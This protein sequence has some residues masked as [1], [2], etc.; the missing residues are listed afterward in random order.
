MEKSA[1]ALL[2]AFQHRINDTVNLAPIITAVHGFVCGS[3]RTKADIVSS[4]PR[5]T[6]LRNLLN[7][8]HT[9]GHAYESLLSPYVLHGECVAIG[10]V[11]EAQVARYLGHLSD[12]AVA[13]LTRCIETYK[14]PISPDDAQVRRR[15][16]NMVT[17]FAKLWEVM[18]IDKK[19]VGNDKKVVILTAIGSCLEKK[20]TLV[21]D[22]VFK[23]VLS[24]NV[25]VGSMNNSPPHVE[26]TPPG[27]KSISNRVLVLAALGSG[28]CQIKNLLHS[29][30]TEVMLNAI[31]ALSGVS[32]SWENNCETLVIEGTGKLLAPEEP[33]YL[34]NAGT[35]A[36]FLT[37]ISTLAEAGLAQDT[38]LTGNDRMKQRPIGPLVDALRANGSKIEY[39]E[40]DGSLPLRI[41]AGKKLKGGLI[42]LSATISSQ[43]VSSILMCAP[44]AS[45]PVT[46]ALVG[47]KPISQVFID[48]TIAMM[49]TFGISVQEISKNTYKIPL[50]TYKNPSEYVVESDASSATYPLAFAALSGTS[51]TIP[52]IGSASLQGDARF[53]VDILEP[54]GCKVSQTLTST[55]VQ[56]PAVG[57]LK[58]IPGNVDMEPMTDAFLTATVLAAVS[59]G[60]TRITGIAN[61]RVKECNRI[62]AMIHELDKFGVTT[63]EHSDGLEIDGSTIDKLKTPTDGVDTYDDHR[64]AMSLSLLATSLEPQVLLHDRRCVEKTWP[65]WW[66]ILNRVLKVPLAGHSHPQA[67]PKM[68]IPNED[69]TIV[70]IGMRGAGKSSMGRWVASSLGLKFKDMDDYMEEKLGITIP[71]LIKRDGWEGFR[72]EELQCLDEFLRDKPRGY[73]AACGGGI[74]E[75]PAAR[76]IL[77]DWMAKDRL[78][79]HVHRNIT[80]IV[81]YLQVDK[82]RPSYTADIFDIW[83]RREQWYFDCSNCFY[84]S[85]Y[86]SNS[87]ESSKVRHSLGLFLK[88][89]T[90]TRS[91]KVPRGRSAYLS[92]NFPDLKQVK[93]LEA[94]FVGVSAVELRIDLLRE[95][96]QEGP[97]PSL[98]YVNEQIGYL[99]MATY[100]PIVF[101]IR[102]VS[103]GGK[104]PD[105][106]EDAA[107]KLIRLAYKLG[108]DLV[109]LE[110][111][112]S[113]ALIQKLVADKG[114]T[115][116]IASYQNEAGNLKWDHSTWEDLYVKALAVGD[117]I[118][119]VGRATSLEDNYALETFRQIHTRKP[120]IAINMG[121][122]GKLSRVLNIVLTP[123]THELFSA[124]NWPGQLTIKEIISTLVLIGGLTKKEFFITGNPC[125]HSR[126]PALHNA[127]FKALGLPHEYTTFETPDVALV[128]DHIKKLGPKFGGASVT[129]P[130]K[131]AVIPY[132]HEL[133]TNA[134]LIGAVNTIIPTDE[135]HLYGDNTDWVGIVNSFESV[136]VQPVSGAAGQYAAMVIGAGGTSRAA[137][138]ALNSLGFSTIYLLNRTTKNAEEVASAFPA[139][140]GIQVMSLETDLQKL[141]ATLRAPLLTVS[142]VPA[143]KPLSSALLAL[144][145]HFLDLKQDKSSTIEKTLLDVAYK[146]YVT[147][148]MEHAKSRGFKTIGGREMLILQGVQQ[149]DIWTG[150]MAPIEIARK[151]VYALDLE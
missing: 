63:R 145:N 24:E 62:D 41:S 113:S 31:Q 53:A 96:G 107:E 95:A 143:D 51:C 114:Y 52:N 58:A 123:V 48:M 91:F 90:G 125:V 97:I 61:Q 22:H 17:P 93:D 47:G 81:E 18:K 50:G 45:E 133:T 32:V 2:H 64:V 88:T 43:Y 29:D 26:I 110:L 38:I 5:E 13:R 103:Q 137:I 149:F 142:C 84:F 68:P 11:L 23:T 121:F 126:S 120:L 136:G 132:L 138:V 129:I 74:V 109:D 83:K 49:S 59:K 9:I 105:D 75:T 12:H 134:K 8:G 118:R 60:T 66:D 85:T 124:T 122:E 71:E 44:Y 1:P 78:V 89:I 139:N 98:E 150:I 77:K 135:G 10:M 16:K 76:D 14:L 151:A 128:F 92:L 20:A 56:G 7:F 117:I 69:K 4:D 55:T 87:T 46:L 36:R 119:F 37:T 141:P 80:D 86:F 67:P 25:L 115:R 73:V 3:I 116:L 19:T 102:T 130:H 79:L 70:V 65:G 146:P 112:W 106:A 35:A 15:S 28:R 21:S 131:L 140:F 111:T 148:L 72:Q 40:A 127:C 27:S 94:S 30:D 108:V 147:P 144:I 82:T 42:E 100:L 33:L 39:E 34:G 104:F 6:G 57:S 101:T 54:M 99:R